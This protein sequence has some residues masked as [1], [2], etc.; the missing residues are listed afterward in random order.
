MPIRRTLADDGDAG[1]SSPVARQAHNLKV[2]GSNPTPATNIHQINQ[3]CSAEAR[4]LDQLSIG[5]RYVRGTQI[6]VLT[7]LWDVL[8]ATNGI[9]Q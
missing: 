3:V 2:V 9:V 1:W 8:T 4:T 6:L 5:E 7:A